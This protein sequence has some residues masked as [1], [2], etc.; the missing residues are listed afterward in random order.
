MKRNIIH[1]IRVIISEGKE[2]VK[3]FVFNEKQ[4]DKAITK[5]FV[6]LDRAMWSFESGQIIGLYQN[7]KLLRYYSDPNQ[8]WV[9]SNNNGI[10]EGLGGAR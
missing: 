8:G 9:F 2:P 1:M 3:S 5:A 10:Y 6:E 4:D 7:D